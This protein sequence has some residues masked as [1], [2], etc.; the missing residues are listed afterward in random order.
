MLGVL[1]FKLKGDILLFIFTGS[2]SII[3]IF[4]DPE[5]EPSLAKG[6]DFFDYEIPSDPP[7]S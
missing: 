7:I 3:I 4:L 5:P 6:E 2:A 1:L